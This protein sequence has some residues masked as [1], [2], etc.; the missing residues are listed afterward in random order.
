[1]REPHVDDA[2]EVV[3]FAMAE[4]VAL[5]CDPIDAAST[6]IA[7]GLLRLEDAGSPRA[8]LKVY[9][10]FLE[11]VLE[12]LRAIEAGGNGARSAAVH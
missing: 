4:L 7:S 11:H 6:L 1:M 8:T 9:R 10:R 2:L 5:G 3:D 12:T